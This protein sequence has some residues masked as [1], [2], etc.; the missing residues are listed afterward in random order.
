MKEKEQFIAMSSNHHVNLIF[1]W[2]RYVDY[3]KMV[4]LSSKDLCNSIPIT[5]E[6]VNQVETNTPK[7]RYCLCF[8][9][10]CLITLFLFN[11]ATQTQPSDNHPGFLSGLL[12]GFLILFRF[13]A[14]LFTDYGIYAFPNS[15]HWYDLGY[16]IGAGIFWGI[17]G[18]SLSSYD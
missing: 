1:L 12:H 4:S 17:G 2:K 11:C 10:L 18:I 7:K 8:T 15:G 9:L 13:I 6:K 3:R 14:S 16:L 5:D